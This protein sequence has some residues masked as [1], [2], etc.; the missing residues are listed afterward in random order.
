MLPLLD[1][2]GLSTGDF[3]PALEQFLGSA[4]GLSPATVT[5][6]TTQWQADHADFQD[7]DLSATDYVYVW[8]EGIRLRIRLEEAKSAVLALMGV[9]AD[10]TKE[11]IAMTDGDGRQDPRA[12]DRPVRVGVLGGCPAPP[13]TD[14]HPRTLL[15]LVKEREAS[16][17]WATTS[18]SS[19]GLDYYSDLARHHHVVLG[20]RVERAHFR[21]KSDPVQLDFEFVVSV[22][23]ARQQFRADKNRPSRINLRDRNLD[24]VLLLPKRC[25]LPAVDHDGITTVPADESVTDVQSG[26]SG[27]HE[28]PR[29]GSEHQV[30]ATAQKP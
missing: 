9:R 11:L 30:P 28:F 22:G 6:L 1:L 12:D 5:R 8:A 14:D 21:P 17:A 26:T 16:A 23:P 4:A 20:L 3:V 24:V 18:T 10:G 2:H 29:A 15:V 7:R 25:N 19:T 27:P 13:D